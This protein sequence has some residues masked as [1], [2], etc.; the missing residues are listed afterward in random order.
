MKIGWSWACLSLLWFTR[1]NH[2]SLTS[3]FPHRVRWTDWADLY[4]MRS[5]WF[6]AIVRCNL[7]AS[8]ICYGLEEDSSAGLR[9]WCS[10]ERFIYNPPGVYTG[11][12]GGCYIQL[13]EGRRGLQGS[14]GESTRSSEYP[15]TR[16]QAHT[17]TLPHGNHTGG[18]SRELRG[19]QRSSDAQQSPPGLSADH[20]NETQ[21]SHLPRAW[22]EGVNPQWVPPRRERRGER[23]RESADQRA[24]DPPGRD[25]IRVNVF[26][27]PMTVF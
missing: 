3:S 10:Q 12:C 8:Y 2:V 16:S 18:K 14:P 11:M 21:V 4:K 19:R 1:L 15:L 9:F 20:L 23:K 17:P 13:S 26:S 24:A 25:N 27:F 6:Y 22:A 7:S 5:A